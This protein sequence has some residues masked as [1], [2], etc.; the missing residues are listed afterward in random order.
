MDHLTK[1]P[2]TWKWGILA[3][4]FL[5]PFFFLTYGFANQYAAHLSDVKSIVFH[6]EKNIPLLPW[7]IVPYWSIDL[8][9]GLSLLLCV[10][11][12]ELKQHTFRLF[13]AQVISITCFIL[14][15]LKFSFDRPQLDGF[16]GLWFDLLM[17]FD[18][19]FNQAPSLHIVLLIILWNFY[20]N[21]VNHKWKYLVDFWS[22]LIAISVLT[23][24][25]H[26]FIDIPTGIIVGAFCL[27]LFPI[28]V[29]SPL[30]KENTQKLTAKHFKVAFFYSFAALI[31]ISIAVYLK[32]YFLWLLYPAISLFFVALAYIT[33]R[34]HFFQK[35]INGKMTTA[36][37]I[38]FLPYFILAWINSRIWTYKHPEDS[39]II[40]V[41][42]I[43]I[44]IGRIPTSQDTTHYHAIFDCIA[45]LPISSLAFYQ[46]YLSLDL[47]PLQPNQLEKS[48]ELLDDLFQEIAHLKMGK[49]LVNCALGYSRSSAV[50][51]AWLIKNGYAENA[52]L[53]VEIIQNKRPWVKLSEV[54]IQNL[55][56]YR[57]KII[58]LSP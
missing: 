31:L 40:Q 53:A 32:S 21:H 17:G 18:K 51:C 10:N 56:T 34:P 55:T 33:V 39:E 29:T 13:L 28:S 26:H 19:P 14:F 52:Q 47:I 46:Q 15:P 43:T 48:V 49:L 22:I 35:R 4:I 7:T 57:L 45:E 23:T 27:W 6:W 1:Q 36:A 41:N 16:F 12:F 50:L 37:Q 30:S 3:L 2:G 8:F 9:Y 38:I 20:R 42:N 58:G 44:F 54:Q 11:R 24:W 5:A 25:Q